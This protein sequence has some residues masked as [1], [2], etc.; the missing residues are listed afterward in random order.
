MEKLDWI[1]ARILRELQANARVS[2]SDLST[3]VGLSASP[4]ARRIRHLEDS[5]VIDGYTALL[6]EAAMGFGM[7]VFVSVQLD[8]QVDEALE[9]FEAAVQSFP[10]VVDCWLMTGNRDYLL[11]VVTTD[12]AGYE[13]FL[14]G[15]LTKV[16]GVS[17][18]ES[19]IPLRRV[20]TGPSRSV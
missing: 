5:G 8:R 9:E 2:I 20:K 14:V 6:N 15:Q 16:R 10:E 18:I 1:D 12:L 19:S 17:S 7:S 11:R 13:T 3:R 4:V